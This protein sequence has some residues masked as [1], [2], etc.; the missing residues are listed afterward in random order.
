MT[1]FAFVDNE[2]KDRKEIRSRSREDEM[3]QT[4]SDDYLFP[5][6]GKVTLSCLCL[7]KRVATLV[8]FDATATMFSRLIYHLK[9][10]GEVLRQVLRFPL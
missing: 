6:R 5:D 10:G 7:S 3:Q 1:F 2:G 9:G 4:V 8:K